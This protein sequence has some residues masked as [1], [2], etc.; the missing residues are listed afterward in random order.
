MSTSIDPSYFRTGTNV[1]LPERY[2]ADGK[3][4]PA[5]DTVVTADAWC[6]QSGIWVCRVETWGQAAVRVDKLELLNDRA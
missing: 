3:L 2:G 4:Y 1:R 6:N 5:Q